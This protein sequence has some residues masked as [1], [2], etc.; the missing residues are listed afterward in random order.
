MLEMPVTLP[1]FAE[2]E[3]HAKADTQAMQLPAALAA[4][5]R[6]ATKSGVEIGSRWTPS[7]P[8][9]QPMTADA[10]R[11]QD[12]LLDERTDPAFPRSWVSRVAGAVWAW[13]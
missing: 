5:A 2:I 3:I 10:Q 13:C 11:L 9:P 7:A 4:D 8:G 6:P 1:L 12:A